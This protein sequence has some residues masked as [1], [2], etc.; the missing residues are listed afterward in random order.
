M[1]KVLC[2]R[3]QE[4]SIKHQEN[5]LLHMIFTN[6]LLATGNSQLTTNE[7]LRYTQDDGH[8]GIQSPEAR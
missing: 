2:I 7:I 5:L 6:Q 3:Y 4:S 1:S 8:G